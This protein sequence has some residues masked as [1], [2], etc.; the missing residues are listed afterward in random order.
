ML[1]YNRV[2]GFV[3]RRGHFFQTSGFKPS[4]NGGGGVQSSFS[5]LSLIIH[6]LPPEDVLAFKIPSVVVL[7]PTTT[8]AAPQPADPIATVIGPVVDGVPGADFLNANSKSLSHPSGSSRDVDVDLIP[9]TT[10][11]KCHGCQ[12]FEKMSL[13]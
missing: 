2:A 13:C 12:N 7:S 4:V 1:E 9:K 8:V 11:S 6:P 5:T 3:D 10:N